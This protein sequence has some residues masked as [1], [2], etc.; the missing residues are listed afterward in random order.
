MCV[1][2]SGLADVKWDVWQTDKRNEE[3]GIS[4]V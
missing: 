3:L 1:L 4:G 2:V